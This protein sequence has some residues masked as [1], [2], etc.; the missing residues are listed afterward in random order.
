MKNLSILLCF[1]LSLSTFAKLDK[2]VVNKSKREMLLIEDGNI[3]Y[4]FKVMLSSKATKGPKRQEGDKKVPE[5]KY[6]LNWQ[7][8]NSKYYKSIHINYPTKVDIQKSK[9]LGIDNPGGEIFIH[10][11][12]NDISIL[13]ELF[14]LSFKLR[15]NYIQRKHAN[16]LGEFAAKELLYVL[17]IDWT[18][19][20]IALVDREVDIVWEEYY[21]G[22]PI[23]INP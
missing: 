10:G 18:A 7:N 23:I 20:C 5:G 6:L 22:L 4:K 9:D 12:P 11:M 14:K 15:G 13:G 16:E 1:L 19:G 21:H 17:G 3:K 2:I 8:E